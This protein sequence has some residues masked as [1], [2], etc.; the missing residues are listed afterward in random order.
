MNNPDVLDEIAG[1]SEIQRLQYNSH[2]IDKIMT[3]LFALT[4]PAS[5]DL[6]SN[7]PKV[8]PSGLP[9]AD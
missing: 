6:R 9:L 7:T 2:D 5:L 3:F 4:D 1:A 8:L